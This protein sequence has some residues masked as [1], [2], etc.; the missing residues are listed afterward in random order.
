MDK[1]NIFKNIIKKTNN[2]EEKVKIINIKNISMDSKKIEEGDLFVAIR[3]GNNYIEEALNKGALVVYDKQDS[4]NH[5][6][7]LQK[8]RIFYVDDSIYFLQEFAQ[9]WRE[10]NKAK[11]IAIT[12]SNGKTTVK[13]ITHNLLSS[14]YKGKKTDG[15]Y[16]NHIGLPFTLLRLE[17]DD[18]YIILEMGMSDFGEIDLLGKIARPDISII[19]NIGESHLEF[20]KTK[21]NVFKAKTEIV[22]HTKDTLIIN[23]DDL[24]LKKINENKEKSSNI[25]VISI[26]KNQKDNKMSNKLEENEFEYSLLSMNDE[27]TTFEISY[28][29]KNNIKKNIFETNLLGE[30]NILN[31]SISIAVA[32]IM[33]VEDNLIDQVLR[34]ITLTPMRFQKIEK[35]GILFIND[36]YNASPISMEKSLKTFDKIYKDKKKIA[37]LGDML[38][39]GDKEREYHENLYEIIENTSI[40]KVY[41]F[42]KRMEDLY[43]KYLYKKE[44]G[45][46]I[47]SDFEY[48]EKKE[49]I[50]E[51]IAKLN[52]N[53]Y[54]VLL[55]GSRGMKLEDIIDII[56]K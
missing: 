35:K 25:N 30:H 49:N 3:G 45:S 48:Y 33:N 36:A 27:K 26:I 15:N 43:K 12:G 2:L 44:N 50:C 42:G 29:F 24:Y 47:L 4:S 5:L 16:N 51:L 39:L 18:E 8:E 14:K 20:L 41:L 55:K 9:K 6:T 37:V 17:E 52:E 56:K 13:D 38:E 10:Y 32:K 23:G 19:T 28:L 11:V 40:E 53:E 34:N 54:V 22:R 1:S 46:S 7:K 21:E 31:T